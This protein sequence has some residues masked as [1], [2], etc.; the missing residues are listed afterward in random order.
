VDLKIP[1]IGWNALRFPKDKPVCP[2]FSK[3]RE[4]D[5]VYFVHSYY[6]AAPADCV[7]AVTEYGADLTAAVHRDNVY[8]CQFHPEKSGKVGLSILNAFLEVKA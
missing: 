6:A 3:I 2:L 7:A 4:G 8:G 1:Q 5:H